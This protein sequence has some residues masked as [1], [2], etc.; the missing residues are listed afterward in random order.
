MK[1]QKIFNIDEYTWKDIYLKI[2]K[3]LKI[4]LQLKGKRVSCY[5]INSSIIT[6]HGLG[7]GK[8][9]FAVKELLPGQFQ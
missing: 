9:F 7:A 2:V 1:V 6:S 3:S 5:N 8:L 4:K